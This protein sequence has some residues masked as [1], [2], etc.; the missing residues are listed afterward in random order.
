MEKSVQAKAL[1]AGVCS[2]IARIL[3]C[4][5][6]V[7]RVIF[8]VLLLAKTFLAIIAYI[9]LALVFRCMGHLSKAKGSSAEESSLNSPELATRNNR[10]EELDRRFREW[11]DSLPR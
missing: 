10:I 3:K 2:R 5:V 7:L 9:A 6:W 1:L 4:D 11:E 8:L